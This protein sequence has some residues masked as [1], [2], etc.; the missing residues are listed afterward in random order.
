MIVAAGFSGNGVGPAH[1]AG[2]A[3]AS[4]ALRRD[5]E[6]ARTLLA[7][8]PAGRLPP[9]PGTWLGG[10]VVKRALRRKEDAEDRG[11][12]DGSGD[13]PPGRAGS[14]ELRRPRLAQPQSSARRTRPAENSEG[15]T[16]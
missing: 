10:Q 7:R 3:L 2:R 14:H 4:M 5:D 13:A 8:A 11:G 6:W 9:E 16:P 15:L 1:T 12:R